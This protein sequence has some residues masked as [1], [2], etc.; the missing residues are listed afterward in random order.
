MLYN[1]VIAAFT[2]P[3][4]QTVLGA[5]AQFVGEIFLIFFL[6]WI[7]GYGFA[8]GASNAPAFQPVQTESSFESSSEEEEDTSE[9]EDSEEED[10][11]EVS[12]EVSDNVEEREGSVEEEEVIE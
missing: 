1:F 4:S 5:T 6:S 7:V 11:S 10:G 3:C 2:S 12:E 8:Q 9:G